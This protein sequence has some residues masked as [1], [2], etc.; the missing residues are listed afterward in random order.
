MENDSPVLEAVARRSLAY[1]LPLEDTLRLPHLERCMALLKTQERQLE[2]AA[3]LLTMAQVLPATER[4][5]TW[6]AG[7]EL[8]TRIG[9]EA[10]LVGH[11]IDNPPYIPT[12][13]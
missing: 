6:Q 1:F 11:S 8:L 7:A 12:L 5:P 3:V 4:E 10:W 13:V 9:A 2:K